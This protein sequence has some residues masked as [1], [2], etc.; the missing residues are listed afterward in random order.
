MFKKWKLPPSTIPQPRD[1]RFPNQ[2]EL[3]KPFKGF[4]NPIKEDPTL[5]GPYKDPDE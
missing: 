4:R 3:C 5:I 2:V 1:S